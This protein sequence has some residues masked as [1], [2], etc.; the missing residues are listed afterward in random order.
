[1]GAFKSAIAEK[2][3]SYLTSAFLEDFQKTAMRV[4]V[5]EQL[6]EDGLSSAFRLAIIFQ[7]DQVLK[8]NSLTDSLKLV[9]C[10]KIKEQ[11]L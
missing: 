6:T 11:L 8:L 5:K 1:M 7:V 9:L 3:N 10:T 2:V 4:I